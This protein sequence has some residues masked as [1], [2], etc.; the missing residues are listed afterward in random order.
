MIAPCR[1][2]R[3]NTLLR[4]TCGVAE[5]VVLGRAAP[6]A[7]RAGRR[8]RHGRVDRHVPRGARPRARRDVRVSDRQRRRRARGAQPPAPGHQSRHRRA[9]RSRRAVPDDEALAR[10]LPVVRRARLAGGLPLARRARRRSQRSARRGAW[11]TPG[12]CARRFASTCPSSRSA[13][14]PIR[15][16]TRRRR[17][18]YLGDGRLQ[19]RVL[20]DAG[21]VASRPR[22]RRS[23]PRRSRTASGCRLP[24]IFGVFY[25]RSAN[26]KTL[27][28]LQQFLPVPVE[29]LRAEF[30]A[31]ASAEEICARTIRALRAAGVRHFYVSNLPVGRRARRSRRRRVARE[32]WRLIGSLATRRRAATH[33]PVPQLPRTRSSSIA[34]AA[35]RGW[36]SA[37]RC[38][39]IDER[40]RIARVA[41]RHDDGRLERGGHA[42]G[43]A[44]ARARSKP[45][46]C[47]MDS[48]IAVACSVRNAD[49]LS[50][51]VPRVR[52]RRLPVSR[53]ARAARPRAPAPAPLPP[54]RG[55]APS[56]IAAA[57][58]RPRAID[59][60][61]G[62]RRIATAARCPTDGAQRAASNSRSS[63]ARETSLRRIERA[64]TPAAPDEVEH[65]VI[66]RAR[67]LDERPSTIT[68]LTLSLYP[69]GLATS[70]R[71][72]SPA[73]SASAT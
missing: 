8:R 19:R 53:L 7:R 58:R 63:S 33:D 30:A 10:V 16:R 29:G 46:I 36:R 37:S 34:A 38:D 72:R 55:S 27:A 31:G 13:A 40:V 24:G 2:A 17:C 66:R 50:G 12:S 70:T 47:R 28:A 54:T 5:P 15:T 49:G 48:P 1:R 42:A 25:Y 56:A 35:A 14:G 68:N 45:S 4:R 3:R 18:G 6:A 64:R 32:A 59:A 21:R 67:A 11:S 62:R 39:S 73:S 60:A 69:H 43:F 61:I 65:L 22:R 52:V 41:D 23:L 57:R 9:A 44:R 26:P 51:V 71:S 20:P